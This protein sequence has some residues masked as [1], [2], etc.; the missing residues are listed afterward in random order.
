MLD[1]ENREVELKDILKPSEGLGLVVLDAPAGY[2]KSE[3]LRKAETDASQHNWICA[4]IE[5]NDEDYRKDDYVKPIL[6]A[7]AKKL[8]VDVIS[9]ITSEKLVEKV[10]K[11]R[12]ENILLL[13]DA[14]DTNKLAMEWLKDNLVPTLECI[15]RPMTQ[16]GKV[17]FAGRYMMNRFKW[18]NYRPLHLDLLEKGI[19]R[20][21]IQ[22]KL[23]EKKWSEKTRNSASEEIAILS[24]GHPGIARD[25]LN[26]LLNE[27]WT[28]GFDTE[29]L[30]PNARQQIIQKFVNPTITNIL[31]EIENE[32]C[33]QAFEIL[34][35]F[36]RYHYY[37]IE[38]LRKMA[39]GQGKLELRVDFPDLLKVLRPFAD[40]TATTFSGDWE[41]IGLASRDKKDGFFH[42]GVIR[43]LILSQMQR[44]QKGR[45]R[46]LNAL[47]HAL[48]NTLLNDRQVNGE[49]L[50]SD[51]DKKLAGKSQRDFMAES[52][53]HL[54]N[55]LDEG[56]VDNER[57]IVRQ[58]RWYRERL[59]AGLDSRLSL[60]QYLYK[61]IHDDKDCLDRLRQLLGEE[62]EQ[63]MVNVF[64]AD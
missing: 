61:K 63:R 12:E 8:Q 7:L 10:T 30:S 24:C 9:G 41:K 14:A 17:L 35:V 45:F 62:G 1:F 34:C 48:C 42:N 25:A 21:A 64:V 32:G 15:L 43:R 6:N 23:P 46:Q 57:C 56:D 13:F 60:G 2:G 39:K 53:Y 11:R 58:I 44:E 38:S 51:S 55:C 36:R 4:R 26:Y 37:T 40:Q 31:G 54:L 47:G 50:P 20:K 18:K 33:R 59:R 52:F 49:Q 27:G 29:G 5:L 28:T 3:L 16:I 19:I 22:K